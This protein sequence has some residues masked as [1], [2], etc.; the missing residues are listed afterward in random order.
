M[1]DDEVAALRA[2]LKPAAS[3]GAIC[4]TEYPVQV[5]LRCPKAVGEA[6]VTKALRARIAA[7]EAANAEL[8][9]KSAAKDGVIAEQ[10]EAIEA[11]DAATSTQP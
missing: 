8:E 2:H 10:H 7:L 3:A 1:T 9:T 5:R 4:A 6:D 11:R